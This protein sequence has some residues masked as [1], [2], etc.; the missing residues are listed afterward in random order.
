MDEPATS[1]PT[2]VTTAPT[3]APTTAPTSGLTRREARW[4]LKRCAKQG[5]VLAHIDDAPL[6]ARFT[7]TSAA[8]PLLRCLRCGV[9]T[10]DAGTGP[11]AAAVTSADRV[12]GAPDAPA[13]LSALPLALRG[14]HG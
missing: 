6:A 9:F 7:A 11:R 8:G 5:H 14:G 4:V 10:A 1:T 3:A 13:P 2:A 12:I